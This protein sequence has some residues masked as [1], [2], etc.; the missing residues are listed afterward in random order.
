MCCTGRLKG[1]GKW[2]RLYLSPTFT[3]VSIQRWTAVSDVSPPIT[4]ATTQ[5]DATW[6]VFHL[7]YD[8]V[9]NSIFFTKTSCGQSKT[10]AEATDGWKL[11]VRE[12][13]WGEQAV[14]YF[15]CIRC[16][17]K[18]RLT[19]PLVQFG[20]EVFVSGGGVGESV[21]FHKLIDTSMFG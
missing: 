11:F 19:I 6:Q 21:S 17:G 8:T 16:I 1:V 18:A 13:S 7:T 20:L 4:P 14:G 5:T 12:T 2:W 9:G 10:D 3:R 15:P